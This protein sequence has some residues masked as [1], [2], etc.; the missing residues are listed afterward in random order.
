[1]R[2]KLFS[3]TIVALWKAGL[4]VLKVDKM[5]Y[6]CLLDFELVNPAA[7]ILGWDTFRL[8]CA[9]FICALRLQLIKSYKHFLFRF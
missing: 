9:I 8:F 4:V 3:K 2:E 7:L 1:M 6:R 5:F